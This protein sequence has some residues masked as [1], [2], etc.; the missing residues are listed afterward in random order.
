MA[1]SPILNLE[2]IGP[3]Q[4]DKTTSMNDLIVAIEAATNAFRVVDMSAGSV[5]LSFSQLTTSNVFKCN[6][7]TAPTNL[8]I[9]LISPNSTPVIRVFLVRNNGAFTVTVGGATGATVAV[10][11]SNATIIECDGTDCVAYG[12]GGVGLT[13]PTGPVGGAIAMD[14]GYITSTSD[15]DPGSG[16]FGFNTATQNLATI[17]YI[18]THDSHGT[19][20]TAVLDT[21]DEST[22]TTKGQIRI[23]NKT[24]PT[25]WIVF[26]LSGRVSASGYRKYGVTVIGSSGANPFGTSDTL[27]FVFTQA[28][29]MP[30]VDLRPTA[31]WASTAT[32][33]ANTYANGTAGVGA[34]LT[35]T[36]NA[37]L[38]IDGFAVGANDVVL[39]KNEAATSHNG[40]YTVTAAGDGSH[41]YVL[42]RHPQM[43]ETGEFVGGFL[44][45]LGGSINGNTAW[46]CSN[47]TPP[48]IGTTA[49]AFQQ[50][51]TV[52]PYVGGVGI[53][54]S[55]ATIAV[56]TTIVAPLANPHFTG[57]VTLGAML[58]GAGT[59]D[60]T[61]ATEVKV[62]TPAAASDAATKQYV[63]AL[64]Q[65]LSIKPAAT[66]AT[67]TALPANTYF[68]GTA[69]S[70]ATLTANANGA[71]TVDGGATTAGDVVLV[72]NE[73]AGAHN[74]LYVVTNAG[75]GAAAYVLTR[76]VDMDTSTKYQG[77]FIPVESLGVANQNSIWLCTNASPPTVGTTVITFTELVAPQSYVPGTGI[78]ISGVTISANPAIVAFLASP[79][80]TGTV[81]LPAVTAMAGLIDLTGATEVRVPVPSAAADATTKAYVDG[82]VQGL[83]IKPSA[84]WA[85]AAALA[86]N[87]YAN[88]TA[89]VGATL[90]KNSNGALSVDGNSPA[91]NDTVLVKDE[92]AGAH[93]GLYLVTQAGDGS[94]PYI[95]TRSI[96]MDS[97]AKYLGAFVVIESGGAANANTMWVCTNVSPPTV[98][99][100]A[101]TFTQLNGATS[102]APGNGIAI[103]GGTISVSADS[104]LNFTSGTLGMANIG[105]GQVWANF[106]V[107]TGQAAGH[108]VTDVFDNLTNG[109]IGNSIPW[110]QSGGGSVWQGVVLGTGLS[111]TSNTINV[112]PLGI[113]TLVAGAGLSGGT[114]TATGTFAADWHAGTVSSITANFSLAAG[115]L[116]INT[117]VMATK[118]YVDATAQ[119]LQ[120]KP[121]AAVATTTALTGVYLNGTL[122]VG[123]T[124]T[125]TATGVQVID[126]YTLVGGEVVLLKDQAF[127]FQNGLYTVTTPGAIGVATIFTRHVDM[128]QASEFSGAFV[129]VGSA[130]AINGNSLWLANPSGTVVVGTTNIPFTELN[131][132]TDLVG[133]NLININAN[134]INVGTIV[135]LSLIGNA[136]TGSA[137]AGAI[138]IGTGLAISGGTLVTT[139]SA[140]PI[141]TAGGDL[142]GSY[143]NPDVKRINGGTLGATTP[144]SGNL[145]IAN[146]SSWVS[147]PLSGDFTINSGG[148]A[149]LSKTLGPSLLFGNSATTSAVAAGI[150]LGT[151]FSLSGGTLNYSGIAAETIVAGGV[152]STATLVA[153]PNLPYIGT[154][155]SF[156]SWFNQTHSEAIVTNTNGPLVMTGNAAGTNAIVGRYKTLPG[157]SFTLLVNFTFRSQQGSNAP[158]TG[159]F[160]TDG[161]KAV[162]FNG[163]PSRTTEVFGCNLWND[164]STFGSGVSLSGGVG[165]LAWNVEPDFWERVTFNGT[166]NWK[167]EYSFDGFTFWNLGTTT[168]LGITPTGIGFGFE[169]FGSSTGSLAVGINYW[170]GI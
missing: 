54:I 145:I 15:A 53:I 20:W 101:I 170:S 10:S 13:G 120:V 61:G 64:I 72:K 26:D 14:Y 44:A 25:K 102:L 125:M 144:T 135:G 3:T 28:G 23:F 105:A 106:T 9:P 65:G 111:V 100:T 167:F 55:G 4:D 110:R 89:G 161:T 157:G 109:A 169:Y 154:A 51:N 77:A 86:A 35:A 98:G 139:G 158:S 103:G 162:A 137:A 16:K 148:M 122:G 160:L 126:G 63:D 147:Q 90:T 88:G 18:D 155:P 79:T 71:L 94:H 42:T 37:A 12:S 140:A 133:G 131:K 78:S 107:F 62:P 114:V 33:A 95:L 143:P 48:T 5:T 41:P 129:P 115:V 108:S 58:G 68:N 116:D 124:F 152:T 60:L 17:I 153:L 45:V 75:G 165:N 123:A 151:G 52:P 59:I 142:G 96:D 22:N 163:T 119:G 2:L 104:S 31:N 8:T 74:G 130:G 39:V 47:T 150:T 49:I 128:D 69:G 46:L 134:T 164:G 66:W 38:S 34:T 21:L 92:A 81:T 118:A 73:A 83:Q 146:G 67:A 40:L 76:H 70:N 19:D 1:V 85:T 132:A 32:L 156:T 82:L 112:A 93:N 117:G 27:A 91:V 113:T 149:T 29:D 50:L 24:D 138:P 7:A 159:V 166:T 168:S 141:G 87:T 30:V 99:T 80:F 127:A 6:G 57:T 43:D 97:S 11:A 136:G 84:T 56:D 36:A 121:T